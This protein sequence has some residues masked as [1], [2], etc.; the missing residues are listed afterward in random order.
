MEKQFGYGKHLTAMGLAAAAGAAVLAV[1]TVG[2]MVRE[3]AEPPKQSQ[4]EAMS[5]QGYIQGEIFHVNEAGFDQHVLQ[6]T[7][8]VLVDFYA[9]WC[10]P[11]RML[12]PTLEQ[13]A[14]E[15]PNAKVVKV[16]VDENPMLASRYGINGIPT[17]LVFKGGQLVAQHVG[18][19]TKAQLKALLGG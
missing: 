17:L 12:A 19:A 1:L 16:N 18:L 7:V 9:D 4:G 11:C 15:M 6:S 10:G 5:G 13:L 8:P 3:G 2:C 14:Q